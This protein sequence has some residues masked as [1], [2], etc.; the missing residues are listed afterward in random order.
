MDTV[1]CL[2]SDQV[3]FPAFQFGFVLLAI[4]AWAKDRGIFTRKG[5]VSLTVKRGEESWKN[6]NL[7]YGVLAVVFLQAINTTEAWKGYK[8]IITI[9]DLSLLLYL[10][11]FNAWFRNKTLGVIHSSKEME[12]R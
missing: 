4:Y 3:I 2:L 1:K 6:F 9:V 7:A 8:S 11:F 10:C 5:S 12:E